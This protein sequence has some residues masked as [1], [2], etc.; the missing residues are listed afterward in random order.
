MFFDI[1]HSTDY[2]YA[3]PAAEA[4][5]EAR[6]TPPNHSGQRVVRH[7]ISINPDTP[8]SQYVDFCGNTVDFLSLPYRHKRLTITN[9]VVVETTPRLLPDDILSASV[10][11]AKQILGS[12]VTDIYDYLQPTETVKIGR[13]AH[14]WSRRYLPGNA[15]L[16][17]GLESLNKAIFETFE[18]RKGSTDNSTPLNTVW[19]DRKGVCQD[20]AHIMLAILRTAG[21]PARYVCGYIDANPVT[22]DGKRLVGALATHAW[23]EVLLPGRVWVALDPTNN[24][25]CGERHITVSFGRDF[26]DAT[27]LRGTFKGTGAQNMRVKVLVREVSPARAA[28][29]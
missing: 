5:L 15:T 14:Q 16:R 8:T 19:R 12:S 10:Q 23:V 25:W 11:E 1:T 4:Y 24:K 3:T 18:Y 6:L 29:I 26:R 28:K 2:A 22:P 9:Q 21:F 17:T 27:P 20:F 13:E 7:K